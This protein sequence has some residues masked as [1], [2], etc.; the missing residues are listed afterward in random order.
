MSTR[1]YCSYKEPHVSLYKSKSYFILTKIVT[2]NM[3]IPQLLESGSPLT[4]LNM[5]KYS[6]VKCTALV[7]M[8][9]KIDP[10]STGENIFIPCYICFFNRSFLGHKN[11]ILASC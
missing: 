4:C 1:G 3:Q 10:L 11:F 6:V 8:S 7:E 9:E 5:S 2:P